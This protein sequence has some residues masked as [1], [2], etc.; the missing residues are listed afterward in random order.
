MRRSRGPCSTVGTVARSG[1]GGC[2]PVLPLR[3]LAKA[4]CLCPDILALLA[5]PR[6]SPTEATAAPY[7]PATDS[8]P[9]VVHQFIGS[10]YCR[11]VGVHSA[12]SVADGSGCCPVRSCALP[13]TIPHL[14]VGG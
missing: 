11:S 2:L 3:S 1:F 7:E 10:R 13:I 9:Q 14:I 12:R 4:L 8:L 5:Q 6:L